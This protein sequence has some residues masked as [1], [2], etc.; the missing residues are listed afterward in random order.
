MMRSK[1]VIHAV[2]MLCTNLACI[3]ALP[4][5]STTPQGGSFPSEPYLRVDYR[6]AVDGTRVAPGA[7]ADAFTRLADSFEHL[8]GYLLTRET[9][10]SRFS[11]VSIEPILDQPY[12]LSYSHATHILRS[13]AK[14][15]ERT[16]DNYALTYNVTLGDLVVAK[17]AVTKVT[18]EEQIEW[19]GGAEPRS[20]T[21]SI[22]R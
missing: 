22:A 1:L 8:P 21:V 5:I 12:M 16:T 3:T 9:A 14:Y 20:K 17:G 7:T 10:G 19:T 18:N 15:Y 4:S 6:F 13:F 11:E 2:F